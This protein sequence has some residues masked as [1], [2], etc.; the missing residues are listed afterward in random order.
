MILRVNEL[1]EA[2]EICRKL[3]QVHTYIITTYDFF[4]LQFLYDLI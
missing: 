2:A 4:M 3:V 1:Q